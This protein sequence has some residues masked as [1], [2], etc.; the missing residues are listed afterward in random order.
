MSSNTKTH[1]CLR[2]FVA[3]TQKLKLNN[4][5]EKKLHSILENM[6]RRLDFQ[7]ERVF[8]SHVDLGAYLATMQKTSVDHN[9]RVNCKNCGGKD[10]NV[11]YLNCTSSGCV[12]G[13]MC[14][15]R[16]KIESCKCSNTVELYRL[17][18]HISLV[19]ALKT[20]RAVEQ[21]PKRKATARNSKAKR[22]LFCSRR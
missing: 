11:K 14:A 2:V 19:D 12:D 4:K 8:S 22:K 7:L 15:V 6:P 3:R 10:K 5:L 1:I 13:A 21:S 18:D 17:N 9:N 20:S 16:Y